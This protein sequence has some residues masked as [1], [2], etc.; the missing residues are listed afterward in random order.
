MFAEKHMLN[1][2][3]QTKQATASLIEEQKSKKENPADLS[4]VM[5]KSL[6]KTG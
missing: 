6:K 3:Q 4:N 2:A 5:L 1:P